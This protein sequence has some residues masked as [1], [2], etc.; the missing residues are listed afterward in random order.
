MGSNHA[1]IVLPGTTGT[2]LVKSQDKETSTTPLWEYWALR[3][4][5]A[6]FSADTVATELSQPLYAGRP[7]GFAK[8]TGYIA[9]INT[10]VTQANLKYGAGTYQAAYTN[11][12]TNDPA[13]VNIDTSLAWLST[14]LTGNAVIGWG[15]DWRQDNVISGTMLQNF[16]SYLVKSQGIGKITLIGHSMGGL[17]SRS[18]LEYVGPNTQD[19]NVALVDQLITLGTPHLGAPLALAPMTSTMKINVAGKGNS[20]WF[21]KELDDLLVDPLKQAA[22]DN[23]LAM[24]HDVVNRPA[25]AST[26]QLLPPALLT[27]STDATVQ[28]YASFIK[29]TKTDKSFN[30]DPTDSLPT[31]LNALLQQQNFSAANLQLADTFFKHLSYTANP[32][33]AIPYN[34]IYGVV[35][36][37]TPSAAISQTTTTT[38]F[39]YTPSASEPLVTVDTDGGGDTVVPIPSAMFAGNSSVQTFEVPGADHLSMASNPDIWAAVLPL[40]GLPLPAAG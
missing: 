6:P 15:Y 36:T 38:G 25:G 7:G 24:I 27:Q 16:I 5:I 40:L 19:A 33:P 32:N 31:D 26:Y 28:A 4:A 23:V 12:P 10:L 35:S 11:W 39:T 2:S 18:Y 20:N 1:I 30:I 21:I 34:C 22:V 14:D 13:S 3:E 8:G 29:D 17:V 37:Q 9:L